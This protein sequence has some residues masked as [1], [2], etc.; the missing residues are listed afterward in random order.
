M[1]LEG[2]KPHEPVQAVMVRWY[3]ARSLVH[4]PWLTQELVLFPNRLRVLGIRTLSALENHLGTLFG[5]AGKQEAYNT[6]GMKGWKKK[7]KL[8]EKED[9]V[10]AWKCKTEYMYKNTRY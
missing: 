8:Q 6:V 10:D 7:Q 9:E 1:Y 4:V 2:S 5:D 3:E